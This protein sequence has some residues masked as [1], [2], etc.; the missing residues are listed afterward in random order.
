MVDIQV[1][2]RGWLSF[3]LLKDDRHKDT[4]VTLHCGAQRLSGGLAVERELDGVPRSEVN[5][6]SY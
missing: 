1:E 4:Y 6:S 5:S 2:K 3:G